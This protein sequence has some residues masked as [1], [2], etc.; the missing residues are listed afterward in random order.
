VGGDFRLPYN[1]I[2]GI[3]MGKSRAS[4][5]DR[6]TARASLVDRLAASASPCICDEDFPRTLIG[7][8][9][10]IRRP[11]MNMRLFSQ[12]RT[13]EFHEFGLGPPPHPE[14][15]QREDV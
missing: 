8:S 1:T 5:V 15:C 9:A 3:V 4:P 6:L 10:D 7:D 14:H 2:Y 13:L 11:K 12:Y